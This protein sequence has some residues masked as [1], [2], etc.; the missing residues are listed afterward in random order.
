[1]A[2][3]EKTFSTNIKYI[4]TYP[5]Q[6]IRSQA[7]PFDSYIYTRYIRYHYESKAKKAIL[8]SFIQHSTV[9]WMEGK[10]YV[11]I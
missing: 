4:H 9:G 2:Y 11:L 3:T 10:F 7:T 1:M 5:T 8:L 6:Q